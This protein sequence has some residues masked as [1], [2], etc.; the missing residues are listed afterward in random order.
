M[1]TYAT[2]TALQ[3]HMVGADFSVTGSTSTLPASCI[4]RAEARIDSVLARRYDLSQAYFQTSTA[5]PPIV[6]EWTA[7]LAAG[8]CW[9]DKA[10]AGAGKEAM[11]RGKELNDSVMADLKELRDI[12]LELV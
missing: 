4:T 10:R 12:K 2:I 11:A 6:S 5:T 1:G 7:M 9:Q 3:T 8:Y